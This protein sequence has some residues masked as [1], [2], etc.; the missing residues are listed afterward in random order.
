[1]KYYK[2]PTAADAT[3]AWRAYGRRPHLEI[4]KWPFS[5]PVTFVELL[6][7]NAHRSIALIGI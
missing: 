2:S 3:F 1:M 4:G 5:R 7:F 6:D